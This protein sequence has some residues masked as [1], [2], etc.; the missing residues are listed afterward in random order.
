MHLSRGLGVRGRLLLGLHLKRLRVLL[1]EAVDAPF[2]VHKFLPPGEKRMATRANFDAQIAFV[3]RT[4]LERRTARAGHVHFI[5]GG[6]NPCFHFG[7]PFENGWVHPIL[8][9]FSKDAKPRFGR[10]KRLKRGLAEASK[11]STLAT[12]RATGSRSTGTAAS[13]LNET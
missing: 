13:S 11:G 2:R 8:Q 3:S 9:C 4:S 5:V 12:L 6:M 1:L 10:S 7:N